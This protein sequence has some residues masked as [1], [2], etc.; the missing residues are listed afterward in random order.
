MNLLNIKPVVCA[1][2]VTGAMLAAAPSVAQDT[3]QGAPE[4]DAQKF[5]Y[6]LGFRIGSQIKGQASQD[7][8]DID[9]PSLIAAMQDALGDAEPRISMED[10]QAAMQSQNEKMQAARAQQAEAAVA[11]GAKL[12]EEFAKEEGVVKTESGLLYKI[13]EAGEGDSPTPDN[14]VVVNYAGTLPD[15]TEFDSSYKRGQPATFKLAGIIPGWQEVLQL[16]KPGAS[17][18]V[19]IPPALGYGERGSPPTIPANAT[20]K[21][22][23]ELIEVK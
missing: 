16:M 2:A 5:S 9:L 15:G 14:T 6:A 21:F 17:Y 11:E 13:V 19:V 10:M 22:K 3:L 12:Q 23:I 18:D 4:S 7:N 20:L 1:L 8:V